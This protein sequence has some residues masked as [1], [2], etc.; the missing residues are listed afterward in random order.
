MVLWGKGSKGIGSYEEDWVMNPNLQTLI[1][2]PSNAA[3]KINCIFTLKSIVMFFDTLN[4]NP[5]IYFY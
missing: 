2:V 1:N 3:T 5:R 4:E